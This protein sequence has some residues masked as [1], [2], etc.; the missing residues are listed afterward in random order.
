MNFLFLIA[1]FLFFIWIVRNILF[2]TAL[3]QIKEYRFDR[4]LIHLRETSQGKALIFSP[5]YIAKWLGI[6]LFGFVIENESWVPHFHVIVILLFLLQSGLVGK[7]F[8]KGL[9]RIPVF[10]LKAIFI[11]GVSLTATV[12]LFSFPLMDYFLWLLI[13][14]K[15][16]PFFVGGVTLFLSIP[17][18]LYRDFVIQKAIKLL[19]EKKNLL[20]I[21]ITG[22]YGKSSTKDYSAQILA[23]KF[24][25]VATAGTQNTPIGIANTILTKINDETEVFIVEMGAYG[26][27]EIAGMCQMVNPKIGVITAVNFQH[28]SLFKDL[29]STMAAKYEL[30]ESLPKD[31]I[32]IFNI[33]NAN[34]RILFNKTRKKK[35]VFC[36]TKKDNDKNFDE[37]KINPDRIIAENVVV[38]QKDVLFTARI[39]SL[40]FD[41]RAPLLG[42]H[43]VENILPAVY[44]A[45][46]L[47]VSPVQI[48]DAVLHLR[49]VPRTM[50]RIEK[51]DLVFIDDTFNANP[52]AVLAACEYL[53]IYKGKKMMV[54]QPMIELGKKAE[55]EHYRVAREVSRICNVILLTNRNFYLSILKGIQ[56]GGDKCDIEVGNSH[57]LS[58]YISKHA[59]RGDVVLFE[60]KEA[61]FVLKKI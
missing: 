1:S 59:K 40:A 22:S 9:A 14:E 6:L 31:G 7:E 12:I 2:W 39:D 51:N 49:P 27:G 13:I 29:N 32:A 60:G 61:E 34:A 28:A 23:K 5:L 37:D 16:V 58:E 36:Y 35:K 41:F 10:T 53:R 48:E 55:T 4:V 54:L 25:V 43:A 42:A 57:V 38:N 26:Q 8:I 47:G 11:A 56:D 21:G 15:T 17:T 30:I 46:H 44:I 50:A 18:E 19:R 24:N 20:V 45:H 52:D 3:W 33:N